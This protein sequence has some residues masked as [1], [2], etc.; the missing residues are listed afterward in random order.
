MLRLIISGVFLLFF[1]NAYAGEPAE[2][3]SK[4]EGTWT[5]TGVRRSAVHEGSQARVE[6]RAETDA[7]LDADGTRLVS[8][9]RLSEV[10]FDSSGNATTH[11]DYDRVYW[12]M[13]DAASGR[14]LLGGYKDGAAQP[15]ASTGLWSE[16]GV[17]KVTQPLG[18][19]Y[20]IESETRFSSDSETI[21]HEVFYQDARRL[22]DTVLTYRRTVKK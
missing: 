20:R 3:F 16:D 11:R 21:Y 5:A 2:L 19:G 22:A 1:L 8:R 17:F 18:G 10:E 7:T 9:N 14:Y 4:M 13:P 6:I 15:A 12:V